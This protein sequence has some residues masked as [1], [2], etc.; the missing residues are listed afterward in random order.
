MYNHDLYNDKLIGAERC[1]I[2]TIALMV[3]KNEDWVLV[4]TIIIC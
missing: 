4:I 2:A 1:I 3:V